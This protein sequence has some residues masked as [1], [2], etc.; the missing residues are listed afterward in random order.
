VLMMICE[1]LPHRA[2]RAISRNLTS[3]RH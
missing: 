1:H 2:L 3:S